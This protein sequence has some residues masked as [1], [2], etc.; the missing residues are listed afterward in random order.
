[1]VKDSSKKLIKEKAEKVKEVIVKKVIE[2]EII[3][4]EPTIQK[5]QSSKMPKEIPKPKR[6]IVKKLIKTGNEK[7]ANLEKDI[8]EEA[9]EKVVSGSPVGLYA[10]VAIGVLLASVGIYYV[11]TKV[12]KKNKKSNPDEIKTKD[13]K[14]LSEVKKV[15]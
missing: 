14:S 11:Y 10:G 1:M 5:D 9:F 13:I 12:F 3:A 8:S 15:E 2:P 6:K 4:P 7:N